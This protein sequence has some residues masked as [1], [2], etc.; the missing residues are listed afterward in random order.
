LPDADGA[1]VFYASCLEH[2]EDHASPQ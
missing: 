1:T 2:T